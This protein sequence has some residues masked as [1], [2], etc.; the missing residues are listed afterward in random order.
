MNKV[1]NP[2]KISIL[3]LKIVINFIKELST[4]FLDNYDNGIFLQLN[5]FIIKI[6]TNYHFFKKQMDIYLFISTLLMYL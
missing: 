1:G 2:F 4:L 3:I 6:E 5:I